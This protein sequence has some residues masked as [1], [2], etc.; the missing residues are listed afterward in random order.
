ML[1]PDGIMVVMFTHKASGAW[2]AL[3]SGLG[4]GQK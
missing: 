4:I 3:A 1:K 2:D